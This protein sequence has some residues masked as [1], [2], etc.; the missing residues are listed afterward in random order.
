MTTAASGS[1]NVKSKITFSDSLINTG[2]HSIL[3]TS[4]N[5]PREV[6][7]TWNAVNSLEANKWNARLIACNNVV[8]KKSNFFIFPC[9]FVEYNRKFTKKAQRTRGRIMFPNSTNH[10]ISSKINNMIG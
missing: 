6:S 4:N 8:V 7:Y 3:F 9:Y 5:K 1:Q 2:D 10:N